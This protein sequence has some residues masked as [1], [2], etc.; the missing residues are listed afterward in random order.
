MPDKSEAI[1]EFFLTPLAGCDRD[2]MW[3]AS[4][5]KNNSGK[6]VVDVD[7]KVACKVL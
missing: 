1:P 4:Q 5:N 6:S 3:W 2:K 7:T